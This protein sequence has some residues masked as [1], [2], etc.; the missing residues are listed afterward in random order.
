MLVQGKRRGARDER[1][2]PVVNLQKGL[3]TMIYEKTKDQTKNSGKESEACS[4][5]SIRLFFLLTLGEL[6]DDQTA[7]TRRPR[8]T[9]VVANNVWNAN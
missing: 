3:V 1:M 2:N 6:V 7:S 9:W 8:L 4:K 5:P